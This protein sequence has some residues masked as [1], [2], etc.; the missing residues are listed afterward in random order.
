MMT[1]AE[2]LKG[3]TLETMSKDIVM[4]NKGRN[5]WMDNLKV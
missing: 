1:V 5:A 4:G 3:R 2:R